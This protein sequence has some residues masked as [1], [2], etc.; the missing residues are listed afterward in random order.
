MEFLDIAMNC[1]CYKKGVPHKKTHL[2]A[3]L[4]KF[5]CYMGLFFVSLNITYTLFTTSNVSM[6]PARGL[7]LW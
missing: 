3:P 4:T 5:Y 2:N 7:L 6:R 1:C